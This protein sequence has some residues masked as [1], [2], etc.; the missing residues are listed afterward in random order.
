MKS[1]RCHSLAPR[2]QEEQGEGLLPI[3][4]RQATSMGNAFQ[5]VFE[6]LMRLLPP[7]PGLRKA[8]GG[9]GGGSTRG[10]A[11]GVMRTAALRCGNKCRE[12]IRSLQRGIEVRKGNAILGK[13]AC[14]CGR[15]VA[16]EN[17]WFAV[18]PQ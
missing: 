6:A 5:A 18:V 13:N 1:I 11:V 10:S 17:R 2:A 16:V 9:G 3:H 12:Y 4:P 15:A 7:P 8:E 14:G